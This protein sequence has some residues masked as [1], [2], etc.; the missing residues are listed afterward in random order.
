MTAD[1]AATTKIIADGKDLLQR[2]AAYSPYFKVEM[3]MHH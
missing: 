1:E 2:L 3:A